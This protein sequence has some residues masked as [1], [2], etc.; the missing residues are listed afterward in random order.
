MDDRCKG[1]L[2]ADSVVLAQMDRGTT[3]CT[4]S[5]LKAST[6]DDTPFI[7]LDLAA[8]WRWRNGNFGG[9]RF[10]ASAPIMAH[11]PL[12]DS[13]A[14]YAIG[15]LCILDP[16]PRSSFSTADRTKLMELAKEA[17]Q[18]LQNWTTESRVERGRFINSSRVD[19]KK[20][21]LVQQYSPK[22]SLPSVQELELEDW[23]DIVLPVKLSGEGEKENR[24]SFSFENFASTSRPPLSKYPRAEGMQAVQMGSEEINSGV[25]GVFTLSCQLLAESLELTFA[26]IIAVDM[27][28]PAMATPGSTAG[29][30]ME[31]QMLV[32]AT[33]NVPYPTP[34]FDYHSHRAILDDAE[35]GAALFTD[36]NASVNHYK[37]GL[38]S[39]IGT[40]KRMV[41]GWDG[42]LELREMG[43]LLCGFSDRTSRVLGT[44]VCHH[45]FESI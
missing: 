38:L 29:Q 21:K 7:V 37:T 8:D 6:G 3:P 43:Y 11:G 18:Q 42:E 1:G 15:T 31:S 16:S 23:D 30:R 45:I 4:H 39:K 26:Y 19:W 35:R 34:A 28:P 14:L 22:G 32:L 12:G 44:Q 2:Q 5:N 20:N 25:A 36:V 41:P 13:T 24:S 40:T 10:Y 33:H 27:T 9:S 17:G